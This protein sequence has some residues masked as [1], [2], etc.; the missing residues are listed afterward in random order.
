MLLTK[1]ITVKHHKFDSSSVEHA[2]VELFPKKRNAPSFFTLNIYSLPSC[3][4]DVFECLLAPA[5]HLAKQNLPVVGD[6]NA[7]HSSWGYRQAAAEAIKL[8]EAIC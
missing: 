1:R 3:T 8:H 6:F 4:K 7:A 5:L 2:I